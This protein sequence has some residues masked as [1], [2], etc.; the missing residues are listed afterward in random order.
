M[1][2]AVSLRQLYGYAL[3]HQFVVS[4]RRFVGVAAAPFLVLNVG[5]IAGALA[6]E[7]FRFVLLCA[8]F[9]H[10]TR[11]SGDVALL[12]FLGL[13]RQRDIDTCD[14]SDARQSYCYARA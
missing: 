12:N 11:I 3:A 7:P 2:F 9:I 1:R 6:F 13:N 14:D 5:L 4:A 10:T 8:L